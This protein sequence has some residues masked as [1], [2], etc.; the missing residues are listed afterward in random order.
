MLTN[1]FCHLPHIGERLETQL[2]ARGVRT[3][4][5]IQDVTQQSAL[6]LRSAALVEGVAG[7]QRALAEMDPRFFADALPAHLQWRFYPDFAHL[8][9]FLDIETTGMNGRHDYPTTVTL[10][11]GRTIK[12]YI[13]GLNLEHL[14]DDLAAY[15]VLVTYNGK[16]FDI[17]YLERYFKICLPHA[18]IDLRYVLKHLGYKGGLKGCERALGIDRGDLDGVDGY[19]AVLLW[20]EFVRSANLAALET[21]LAYN[22]ADTVNLATLMTLAYNLHVQRTPFAEARLLP[23]PTAPDLPFQPHHETLARLR[24]RHFGRGYG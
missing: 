6:G 12:Y 14:P 19:Y 3:W 23:M 9:A 10:Y 7:S 11:D 5:D 17:P 16:Q 24:H 21:L 1:T 20:R 4:A 13:N 8:T 2:W 22:I 15:K 18:Q